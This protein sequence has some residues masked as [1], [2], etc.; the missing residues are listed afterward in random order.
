M[1]PAYQID[2]GRT[3]FTLAGVPVAKDMP[4][5]P[6]T[7]LFDLSDARAEVETYRVEA[8]TIEVK[9]SKEVAGERIERLRALGY[10]DDDEQA[11]PQD[12]TTDTPE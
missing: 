11:Q 8:P 9:V 2:L 10:I 1:P 12:P 5:Q 4:G 7:A 3:L 6:L